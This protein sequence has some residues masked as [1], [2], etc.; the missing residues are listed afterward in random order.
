MIKHTLNMKEEQ[1][2]YQIANYSYL[3][4]YKTILEL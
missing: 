3:G 4:G 2:P 1:I